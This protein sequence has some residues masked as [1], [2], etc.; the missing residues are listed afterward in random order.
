MLIAN[1][2]VAICI[3]PSQFVLSSKASSVND[4]CYV[5]MKNDPENP[6]QALKD[7]L[8]EFT[9]DTD[10]ERRCHNYGPIFS[11][12]GEKLCP[13]TLRDIFRGGKLE[14]IFGG[15]GGI[16]PYQTDDFV[17]KKAKPSEVPD[18]MNLL[19]TLN[20]TFVKNGNRHSDSLF[21]P[22][23]RVLRV[24]LPTSNKPVTYTVS[25]K[26]YVAN[27]D[28]FPWKG[29]FDLKG[30]PFHLARRGDS[31]EGRGATLKDGDF[32]ETFPSGLFIEDDE[33]R[34][35]FRKGLIRDTNILQKSRNMDYSV[36]L[37]IVEVCRSLTSTWSTCSRQIS[38]TLN[39]Q[40]P[41]KDKKGIP[42]KFGTFTK[43]CI[44]LDKEHSGRPIYSNGKGEFLYFWESK[45]YIG[46]SFQG[47]TDIVYQESNPTD[48]CPT[49]AVAWASEWTGKKSRLHL[50][51][52]SSGKNDDADDMKDKS[53]LRSNKHRPLLWAT[54]EGKQY[55]ISYGL[56]DLFM[57]EN[58]RDDSNWF[59]S[60]ADK[61]FGL[62]GAYYHGSL[63]CKQRDIDPL[64]AGRYQARFLL[65]IGH[66]VDHPC[67][68]GKDTAYVYEYFPNIAQTN[69]SISLD[70][71]SCSTMCKWLNYDGSEEDPCKSFTDSL[72][73]KKWFWDAKGF[74]QSSLNPV[75][76]LMGR[77]VRRVQ[78]PQHVKAISSKLDHMRESKKTKYVIPLGELETRM[79][80]WRVRDNITGYRTNV[81]DLEGV[82]EFN[83]SSDHM[84]D[85]RAAHDNV[86]IAG[87]TQI[88]VQS[89]QH[90][91]SSDVKKAMKKISM[92]ANR[93][94]PDK[95]Y[96]TLAGIVTSRDPS[97]ESNTSVFEI[98]LPDSLERV[99]NHSI[100]L[101][102]V[103]DGHT[104]TFETYSIFAAR[105]TSLELRHENG[106][107]VP[108]NFQENELRNFLSYELYAKLAE[109]R[110]NLDK[111]EAE[112]AEEVENLS[113]TSEKVELA[114]EGDVELEGLASEFA[115]SAGVNKEL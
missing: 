78:V 101:M 57:N 113:K 68:M 104:V 24:F 38:V 88:E 100:G 28:M 15:K 82:Q 94:F 90:V 23:C 99:V 42:F 115:Y 64:T 56:V 87:K 110:V 54:S 29:K 8:A 49:G 80:P 5:T 16:R 20:Q 53:I 4:G 2:V 70:D 112:E 22:I 10:M 69:C 74:E 34:D 7:H 12:W 98:D 46:R 109:E 58:T 14:P 108:L 55:I 36:L 60:K 37:F 95:F 105:F 86:P 47:D 102:T 59:N 1:V 43:T 91:R 72:E 39:G 77:R 71:E 63:S 107:D 3:I 44:A 31:T 83:A 18:I 13:A 35:R 65:M 89:V 33:A 93:H 32:H 50:A 51:I 19:S 81:T 9:K 62:P 25:L 76:E 27:E 45:W 41:P 106:Y 17:I 114:S 52:R 11:D 97:R 84:V 85:L 96:K 61:V 66:R 103:R 30:N 111:K 75:V 6:H 67:L 21:T 73:A 26:I 79:I 92:I 48:V 40:D